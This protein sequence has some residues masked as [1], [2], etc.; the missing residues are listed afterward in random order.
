MDIIDT[1]K[2]EHQ[3]V[4]TMFGQFEGTD[5]LDAKTELLV[6]LAQELSVHEQAEEEAVWFP[7]RQLL[8]DASAVEDAIGEE[9]GLKGLLEELVL[10]LDDQRVIAGMKQL[11]QLLVAHIQTEE[12]R[13]VP[14]VSQHVNES[15]RVQLAEAY[16][17]SKNYQISQM[18]RL[19]IIMAPEAP[20]E[21]R[22][23][24]QP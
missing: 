2:R 22:L 18:A 23:G 21:Q 1:L 13:I 15:K 4:M 11:K 10:S 17:A 16:V 8:P 14:L 12:G 20:I 3:R 5:S 24:T 7:L 19:N 9:D 6:Q